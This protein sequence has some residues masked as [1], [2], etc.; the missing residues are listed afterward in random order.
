MP[1]RKTLERYILTNKIF[2]C[3]FNA[4]IT[5]ATPQPNCGNYDKGD[6]DQWGGNVSGDYAYYN[7]L[8]DYD[9]RL[10][11]EHNIDI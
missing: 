4:I 3:G 10:D 6:E 11:A 8:L 1:S 5:A 7:N 2:Y 9:Y